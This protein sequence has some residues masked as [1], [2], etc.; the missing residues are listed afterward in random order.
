MLILS[1]CVHIIKGVCWSSTPPLLTTTITIPNNFNPFP[2]NQNSYSGY[3]NPS[4]ITNPWFEG[5]PGFI[6]DGNGRCLFSDY[7]AK[8]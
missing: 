1:I 4:L 3:M 8:N 5:R 7:F 6:F 2:F